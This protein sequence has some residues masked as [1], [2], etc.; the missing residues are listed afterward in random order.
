VL[1]SKS[2]RSNGRRYEKNSDRS[3]FYDRISG[4]IKNKKR[5]ND[6]FFQKVSFPLS[7]S[8]SSKKNGHLSVVYP[9]LMA[10]F[11]LENFSKTTA[12]Q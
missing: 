11:V 2:T 3:I 12:L 6:T 10:I 4:K 9:D 7:N 8:F 5:G 1:T